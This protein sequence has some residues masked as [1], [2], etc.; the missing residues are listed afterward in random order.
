MVKCCHQG[1]WLTS[2]HVDGTDLRSIS[3]RSTIDTSAGTELVC[4]TM[5]LFTIKFTL[6]LV[7]I[8]WHRNEF[9]CGGHWSKAEVGHRSGSKR[10]KKIFW[11]CPS[12]FWL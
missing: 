9:E 11:S 10:R 12:T 8:Q 7:Y 5:C 2:L 4:R 3:R 6:Q 1:Q